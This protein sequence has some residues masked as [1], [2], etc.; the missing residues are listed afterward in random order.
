M[1]IRILATVLLSP[2]GAPFF[3][4][5]FAMHTRAICAWNAFTFSTFSEAE[6]LN[7]YGTPTYYDTTAPQL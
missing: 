5:E 6:A 7:N 4:M 2:L 1:N 3:Y